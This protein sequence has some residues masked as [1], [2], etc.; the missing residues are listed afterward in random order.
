M[1]ALL[2]PAPLSLPRGTFILKGLL[3]HCRDADSGQV[4]ERV[5]LPPRARRWGLPGWLQVGQTQHVSVLGET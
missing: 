2:W 3:R 5:A 1:S 4:M